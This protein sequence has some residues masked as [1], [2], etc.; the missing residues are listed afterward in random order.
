MSTL[1]DIFDHHLPFDPDASLD[2]FLKQIPAKWVVYLF[3]DDADR[4]VQLLCVKNLRS[5]LKR[6][7]GGD[8]L[9]GPTRRVNYR[10]LVRRVYWRR[11][12]SRFEADAVY[13]EAARDIFPQSYRG[14]LGFHPAW[15]VHVDPSAEH[16]RYTKTNQLLDRTGL[17]IGP[18]EDKHAAANLIR[19]IEDAF[20]LCRYH[21]ILVQ[22]PRGLACAYKEMGK[23]PAPCDGSIPMTEYRASVTMSANVLAN[24]AD[25]RLQ[26]SHRMQ[27]AAASLQFELA[28]K[29]Q[30]TLGQLSALGKGPFRH[31]A[32]LQHFTFLSLQRGPRDGTAK[33]FLIT[34]GQIVEVG[35]FLQEPSQ[36]PDLVIQSRPLDLAGVERMG[37][38]SHHLFLPKQSQGLFL[39]LDQLNL[40]Q[41]QKAFRDLQKQKPP[42]DSEGEGVV[43]ELQAI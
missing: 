15:F 17:L 27:Q 5:S 2:D 38:V 6:R 25:Y 12:D 43:K 32:Q 26:Q 7:L 18:V 8:E 31:A 4:P 37:L 42:E 30:S 33:L 1:P 20:D 21:N 24:Q 13:L 35:A 16:P 29:I 11:V 9:I 19:I 40:K 28:G 39:R 34:S 3:A 23:C 22:A 36:L 14:M 10:Q 41:I